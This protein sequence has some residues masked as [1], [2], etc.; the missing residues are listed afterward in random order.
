MLKSSAVLFSV[1]AFFGMK[2]AYADADMFRIIENFEKDDI[3]KSKI[4]HRSPFVY[5]PVDPALWGQQIGDCNPSCKN[6]AAKLK[7]PIKNGPPVVS[8]DDF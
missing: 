1:L 5:Q 7:T 4:L 6:I 8:E 3:K 2:S